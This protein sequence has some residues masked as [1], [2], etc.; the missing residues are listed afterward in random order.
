M[1]VKWDTPLRQRRRLAGHQWT[2][3]LSG[4]RACVSERAVLLMGKLEEPENA[5]LSG[6]DVCRYM[7]EEA[8]PTADE[9]SLVCDCCSDAHFYPGP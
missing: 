6:T 3:Q 1:V 4:T 5:F 7:L 2:T 9:G 8:G